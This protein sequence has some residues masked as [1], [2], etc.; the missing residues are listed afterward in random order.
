MNEDKAAR[1]H[2]LQRRGAWVS[3]ATQAAVMLALVPGG[4]S[5]TIR[6]AAVAISRASV[7][8]ALTVATFT[9]LFLMLLEAVGLPQRFYRTFVLEHRYGL[10]A[11]PLRVWVSDH[12]K[13][14]G[15]SLVLALAAAEF[16]YF[17]LAHWPQWWWAMTAVVA[18]AAIVVLAGLTPVVLLPMFYRF[19]PLDRAALISRLEV[20]SRR[21][22][23]P[24]LGVY[25]WSL[26]DKSR[27]A[28]AA[29]VGAG[30][31]RRILLS[32]TLL[33]HYT[34]D[35]IEVILAHELGHHAHRD[36]R[37]GLAIESLVIV[38][39]VRSGGC[40]AATLL[41]STWPRGPG[42]RRRP[43][44][45]RDGDRGYLARFDAA[46]ERVVAPQRTPSRSLRARAH[47]SSR[48]LRVGDAPAGGAEP[49]RGA[50]IGDDA[51]ALPHAPT[52][53]R[54]HPGCAR[55][56]VLS[57][58]FTDHTGRGS[59]GSPRVADRADLPRVADRRSRIADPRV[60]DR[61]DLHGSRIAR[62][63]TGR[64]SRGSPRVADRADLH[65][66]RIA[67]LTGRGSRGSPR[68]ADHADLHGSR[69]TR[70]L[71]GATETRRTCAWTKDDGALTGRSKSVVRA[72]RAACNPSD[73]DTWKSVLSA[74]R[75]DPRDP[76]CN[77]W[78]LTIF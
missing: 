42:R 23:V 64:G 76:R 9:V 26:G 51:L 5:V 47:R 41:A 14:L 27:R 38:A 63:S 71:H 54:A 60:A 77:P 19:K 62:I 56:S 24:V 66:S 70:D 36:I 3:L 25:E 61:A 18:V 29:L 45:P 74:A 59:R 75:G 67:D 69:I 2:R 31:N 46:R 57:T 35:E 11:A 28:N 7:S 65:G 32:D 49:G 55:V 39:G 20:L 13:G 37:N 33:E 12:V 78:R 10:S 73:R 17:A 48:R 50:A 4:W 58:D 68:V 72:V 40:S 44:A 21:A 52:V 8:S 30:G 1:F 43:A 15:L 53:R 6:D 16:V 22:G 34:D